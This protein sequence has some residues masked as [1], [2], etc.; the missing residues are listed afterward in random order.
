[1]IIRYFEEG[2]EYVRDSMVKQ[3]TPKREG[4]L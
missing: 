3:K 4:P 2:V 1:M